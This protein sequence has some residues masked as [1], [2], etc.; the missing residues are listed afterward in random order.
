MGA[1][2]GRIELVVLLAI[3]AIVGCLAGASMQFAREQAAR[4]E[5][6]NNLKRVALT[7][8]KFHDI[9]KRLPPA[10]GPFP[11]E[12]AGMPATVPAGTLHYWLLP[13]VE[14]GSVYQLAQPAVPGSS[15][16]VWT[17]PQVYSQ[18]ISAYLAPADSTSSGGAVQLSG[19]IPWGA[20]NLAAN[21]RVF[22]G[23][24][25]DATTTAWDNRARFATITN[26]LSSTI[27]FATRYGKCGTGGSAWAGGNTVASLDNFVL[28]GAFFGSDI[29]DSPL[30]PGGYQRY[31]PF[32]L[33]PTQDDCNPLLP[34]GFSATGIQIA[35]LDGS[36]RKVSPQISS[37]TWGQVC[38]PSD[39]VPPRRYD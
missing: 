8:H 15:T 11:V 27:A 12:G 31:P 38:H 13:F 17:L 22:G 32:Q 19:T 36:V 18:V 6:E 3:I 5:T 26:D 34:Q 39:G 33:A 37:I 9:H 24:T 7:L 16:P 28:S 10:W 2:L 1:G 21:A 20:S 23:L 35:L 29:E 4:T 30:T 14:A 25:K